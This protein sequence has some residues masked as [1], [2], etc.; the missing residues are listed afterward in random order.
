[1]TV[2]SAGNKG[3]T[4][5]NNLIGYPYNNVS[6]PIT[7]KIIE[8]IPIDIANANTYMQAVLLFNKIPPYNPRQNRS[9]KQ[10]PPLPCKQVMV[11]PILISG[12]LQFTSN[13]LYFIIRRGGHKYSF[14]SLHT[15]HKCFFIHILPKILTFK[16]YYFFNV[17]PIRFQFT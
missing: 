2:K 9:Y 3:G 10:N 13:I 15:L 16:I 12:F 1:M 8:M 7:S 5:K 11:K 17:Y 14:S 6:T 4:M